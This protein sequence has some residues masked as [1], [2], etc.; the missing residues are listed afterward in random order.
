MD[1]QGVKEEPEGRPGGPGRGERARGA[2]S[3]CLKSPGPPAFPSGS[4]GFRPG[5]YFE[6][7]ERNVRKQFK[8]KLQITSQM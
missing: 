1:C 2:A 7:D 6:G 4:L 8:V 3:S 5:R